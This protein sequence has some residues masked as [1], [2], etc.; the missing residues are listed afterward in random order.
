MSQ[1]S[2]F[3]GILTLISSLEAVSSCTGVIAKKDA[4]ANIIIKNIVK[5]RLTKPHPFIKISST[6]PV[7]MQSHLQNTTS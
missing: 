7:L 3:S 6:N 2:R 1:D 4:L 5:N